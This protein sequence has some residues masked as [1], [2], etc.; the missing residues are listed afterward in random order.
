MRARLTTI[1]VEGTDRMALEVNGHYLEVRTLFRHP[2][3][4]LALLW[5]WARQSHEGGVS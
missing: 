1:T 4:S 3:T 2:L 5:A